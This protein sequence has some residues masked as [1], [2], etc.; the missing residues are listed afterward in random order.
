MFF[1]FVVSG[2]TIAD[3]FFDL[4]LIGWRN[5]LAEGTLAASSEGTDGAAA[6]AVTGTTY[7]FWTP[8]SLPGWIEVELPTG[9]ACDYCAI[10]AHT[11]GSSATAVICEYR[12]G[13]AWVEAASAI[14]ADDEP[15]MLVFPE[16]IASRWR[17]R[18]E[19]GAAPVIG[20]AHIGLSIVMQRGVVAPYTPTS[21]AS[22]IELMATRSLGGQFIGSSIVHR[23]ARTDV[24]FSPL[25][26]AWAR[27]ELEP[28]R[29]HFDGGG[30]FFF[31][32]SPVSS[33]NDIGYCQ[34]DP[35]EGTELR[36][37]YRDDGYIDVTMQI[38]AFVGQ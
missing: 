34:R 32:W 15:L 19:G 35:R 21:I 8:V 6:N 26:E 4:P 36:L 5:R 25:D 38:E 20:V 17:I 11:C 27:L 23:G 1:P 30:C 18:L 9:Q 13:D 33:P 29:R 24:S 2:E 10:A 28:F 14:P 12:E 7:D 22:E 3:P 16:V 37:V 31:A